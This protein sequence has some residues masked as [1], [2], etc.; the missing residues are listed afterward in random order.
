MLAIINKPQYLK[1]QFILYAVILIEG[2]VVLASELLVIRLL[3]PFVGSDT[4]TISIIVSAVLMPL[5]I[6]YY[7]GGQLYHTRYA[8]GK[9]ASIRK[10]LIKN[11]AISAFILAF[12][13]SYT[14]LEVFFTAINNLGITSRILQSTVYV[15][16]FIVYPVYLLGQTTP[17]ISNYFSSEILSKITGKMLFLST[18]GSFSGAIVSSLFLMHLIGVHN[19]VILTIGLLLLL[20]LVLTKKYISNTTLVMYA[21]CL[22]VYFFNSPA[23]IKSLDIVLNNEYHTIYVETDKHDPDTRTLIMNR[24]AM[25]RV[26][27]DKNGLFKYIAYI[28]EEIL[29]YLPRDRSNRRDVLVIGAGGFTIGLDDEVNNYYFVDINEALKE[30]A[31]KHFLQEE[32]TPNKHYIVE[33]ARAFLKHDTR[34]YDVII[35]D[36]FSNTINIPYQLITREYLIQVKEALKPR[37]VLAANIITAPNFADNWAKK[38]DNTFRSVFKTYNRLSVDSFDPWVEDRHDLPEDDY[39]HLID[40]NVLYLYYNKD[41]SN[42]AVYTDDKNDYFLDR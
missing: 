31:E 19:T 30:V 13:L 26:S 5:S 42:D 14:F 29:S 37:G 33:P 21:A 24:A 32:L 12:G 38:F 16:T 28:D 15:L 6:G 2:Y 1:L 36:T 22:V 3:V 10:I 8:Q 35:L 27:P 40:R 9:V 25:S 4:A 34:K 18:V 7:K 41:Y 17:L 23:T 11:I 20:M 39:V